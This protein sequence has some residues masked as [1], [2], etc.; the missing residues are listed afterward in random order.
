MNTSS[1][2]E[3]Y[4]F[5]Y[6]KFIGSCVVSTTL[7]ISIYLPLR[8]LG[9]IK[10][11]GKE[12]IRHA[13]KFG[14]DGLLIVGNHPS[15]LEPIAIACAFG[16]PWALFNL[17]FHPYQTPD[18]I[19]FVKKFKWLRYGAVIPIRRTSKGGRN[20]VTA[21]YQLLYVLRYQRAVILFSEGTRTGNAKEILLVTGLNQIPIGTP[22]SSIGYL[23][24]NEGLNP[25]ILPV[26]S[27]NTHL[28]HPI[29]GRINPF[30]KAKIVFGK[31]FFGEELLTC[32]PRPSGVSDIAYMQML[33]N[34]VMYRIADLDT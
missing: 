13:R 29:K 24:V 17:K 33:S 16:L 20:D 30:A 14:K 5:G 21:L 10:I 31:P 26:L 4:P 25:M 6:G 32:L 15:L 22:K 1:K 7:A 18:E 8:F 2:K 11:E 9:S 3:L 19:N 23:L 34:E 28:I 12:H 27:V